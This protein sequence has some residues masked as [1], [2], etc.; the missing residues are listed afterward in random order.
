[1]ALILR[2]MRGLRMILRE[3]HGQICILEVT[4]ES[5]LEGSR[6]DAGVQA[7]ASEDGPGP[8]WWRGQVAQK[9]D[10]Q[11]CWSVGRAKGTRWG[12]GLGGFRGGVGQ[13]QS[14]GF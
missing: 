10:L 7:E 11:I 4:R 1:M 5:V 3:G 8:V 9:E 14:S 2:T 12:T 13:R 6:V